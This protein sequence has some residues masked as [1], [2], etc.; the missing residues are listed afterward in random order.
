MFEKSRQRASS[1]ENDEL[2]ASF[3]SVRRALGLAGLMLPILLYVEARLVPGEGMQPSI[4]GFYHT[5]MGDVLVGILVAIGLFLIAYVGHK[6]KLGDKLSDW[7]VS[8]IAGI[9][10]IGVAL[11]PVPPTACAVFEPPTVV[12]GIVVHW[13]QGWGVVHFLSAIAFFV[14]MA[15]FC[16]CLFPKNGKGEV[17]YFDEAGNTTYFICG[18]VLL[19]AIAGLLVFFLIRNTA[20]GK[21]L[22]D[23]NFVFWFETLGV[24]AFAI[25]WLTKGNLI[26][27]VGNLVAGRTASAEGAFDTE[28]QMLNRN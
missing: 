20:L 12:Q 14:C 28:E 2:V 1:V 23:G 16:L 5:A 3:L 24:L 22:A 9:G 15:L 13:C 17:R 10:A 27:G 7:W 19:I 8:S 11:F 4:S 26:G 18:V 25:A 21:T 6:P